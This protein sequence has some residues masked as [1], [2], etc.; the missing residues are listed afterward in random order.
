MPNHLRD[1]HYRGAER[2]GHGEDYRYAHDFDG[3][4]VAQDYGVP[5]GKYYRPSGRGHEA[6]IKRRL[7]EL[8]AG[9]GE[10]AAAAANDDDGATDSM[11]NTS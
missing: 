3:A 1:T 8:D 5:R 7:E 11:R 10:D 6:A 9:D 4:Y 2:L